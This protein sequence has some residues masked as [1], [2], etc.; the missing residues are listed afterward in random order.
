VI[1]D[2]GEF[3]ALTEQ[4]AA[5]SEQVGHL[6]D[7]LVNQQDLLIRTVAHVTGTPEYEARESGRPA[8]PRTRHLRVVGGGRR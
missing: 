5:L 3:R 6:D 8:A 4:V 2:T 1:I 7:V